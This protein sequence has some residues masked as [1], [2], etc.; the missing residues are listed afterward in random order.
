MKGPGDAPK[1]GR[2]SSY[3][4][5][6]FASAGTPW[7]MPQPNWR[8]TALLVADLLFVFVMLPLLSG[9]PLPR[10]IGPLLALFVTAGTIALVSDRQAVR[11]G[12]FAILPL[13]AV[14]HALPGQFSRYTTSALQVACAVLIIIFVGRAVFARGVVDAHRVA[15]G[16]ALYLN[17]GLAF[18]TTYTLLGDISPA[19]FSGLTPDRAGWIEDMIH[20][21]LT[22]LT[23]VGY[24]DI[25]P[26]SPLAR[27]I[28]DLEALIGQLFPATLL[29]RLVSLQVSRP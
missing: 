22:T 3:L 16:V 11:F 10:I 9:H 26:R 4:R 7:F 25:L 21:S 17:V 20:F 14:S 6:A 23:T 12:V 2:W 27:S 8:F 29:A 19:A 5:R 1:R 28:A 15:G 18:A 13:A 24:G